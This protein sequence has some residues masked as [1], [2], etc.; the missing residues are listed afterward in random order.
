MT[1]PIVATAGQ[2]FSRDIR[3]KEAKTIWAT[4]DDVEVR[5]QL[6]KGKSTDT[7]LITNLHDKM[8]WDYSDDANPNDLVIKWKMTGHEVRELF[9][10]TTWPKP[11]A[12]KGFFNIIA[13]DVGTTDAHAVVVPTL[14]LKV[15]D[16]TTTES[17]TT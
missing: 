1:D 10:L 3:I 11:K 4:K 9:N 2:P 15:G 5:A 14:V 8:E 12:K 13:S 17:G 7:A 16:T 6:R